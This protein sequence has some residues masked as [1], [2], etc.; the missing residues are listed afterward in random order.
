MSVFKAAKGMARN[1]VEKARWQ[2]WSINLSGFGGGVHESAF[3]DVNSTYAKACFKTVSACVCM[4][5]G[6]R[7]A[8]FVLYFQFPVAS[9]PLCMVFSF[10]EDTW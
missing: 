6:W 5:E 4:Q 1:T 10:P 7:D 8:S 2:R 3:S 9:V